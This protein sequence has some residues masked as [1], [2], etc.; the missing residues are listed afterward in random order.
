MLVPAAAM[1]TPPN[2]AQ[3]RAEQL[4]AASRAD[5]IMRQANRTTGLLPQYLF[6]LHAEKRHHGRAFRVI[7]NQYVSWYQSFIG[8]YVDAS[9]RFSIKQP[10]QKGDHPAPGAN[11]DFKARPAAAAIVRLARSRRAIFFNE[12]HN[13]AL[14]RSLT[15]QMLRALRHEGYTYFAAETL[16]HDDTD[17]QKRGYPTVESGFYTRE[18]VCAEM[19]RTALKLGF[20]VVAYEASENATGDAREAQQARNIIRRVFDKDP[21]ARLVVDAGYAH[22]KES[23]A[24]LGGKSMAEYFRKFTGIDP[25]TIEQTILI[26]HT[27]PGLD[28]PDYSAV[29]RRLHPHTPIVFV[30]AAGKPWTLRDGY[31]VSVFFPP[32]HLRRDRPTWLTLGGLRRAYQVTAD[33]CHRQAPCLVQARYADEGKHAIPADR[34]LVSPAWLQ[35][36]VN[37]DAAV[38]NLPAATDLYLRPGHYRLSAEDA[39]GHIVSRQRITV[40]AATRPIPHVMPP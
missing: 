30:N 37:S 9:A 24:Y 25:L 19:V 18:P 39:A 8:D 16:Y 3:W 32:V 26:P 4:R 7:F 12:A 11:G 2:A 13:V 1:A 5:R 14:T 17:L 36:P 21:H 29:M 20:R 27:E 28:H 31:D 15:V 10:R 35:Q 6:M 34:A 23:G 38:S 33:I 40:P 22:I